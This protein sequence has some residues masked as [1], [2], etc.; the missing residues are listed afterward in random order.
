MVD[1]E[2]DEVTTQGFLIEGEPECE[3]KET[4]M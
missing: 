3:H 2:Y 1:A 4:L